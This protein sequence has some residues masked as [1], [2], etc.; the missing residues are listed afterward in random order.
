MFPAEIATGCAGRG[1]MGRFR[2]VGPGGVGRL[3]RHRGML[4]VAARLLSVPRP[5]VAG[6][7]ESEDIT[8][9]DVEILRAVAA[10]HLPGAGLLALELRRL[11]ALGLLDVTRGVAQLSSRGAHAIEIANGECAAG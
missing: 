3:C 1:P 10:G 11:E 6:V 8:E 9:L 5:T 2:N 7:R 4:G